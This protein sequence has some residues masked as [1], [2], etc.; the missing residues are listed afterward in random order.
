MEQLSMTPDQL[1]SLA[2][3]ILDNDAYHDVMAGI[4]AD[5]LERL[6]S[7][8]REDIDGFYTN[9]AIVKV[10][11]DLQVNLEQ[12]IRSGKAPKAPGIA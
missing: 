9:Q 7:L 5:A 8:K 10:V 2:Q 3:S 11:D 4:R 12:M 6:A 1:A